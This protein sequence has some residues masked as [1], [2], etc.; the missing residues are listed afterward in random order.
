MLL[1]ALAAAA[2][3]EV[4]LEALSPKFSLAASLRTR[5]E[6]WNFFEPGGV[7]RSLFAGDDGDFGYLELTLKI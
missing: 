6:A 5:G 4:P 7:I 3:A 2:R 1:V